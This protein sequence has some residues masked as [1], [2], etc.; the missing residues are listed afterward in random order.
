M[1]WR[2]SKQA[3]SN[4]VGVEKNRL[5]L[6]SFFVVLPKSSFSFLS[7]PE[8]AGYQGVLML[9]KKV[10]SEND[11]AIGTNLTGTRL[12]GVFLLLY[13]K[14]PA[15]SCFDSFPCDS[16]CPLLKLSTEGWGCSHFVKGQLNFSLM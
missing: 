6:F 4:V 14:I 1:H 3:G 12:S 9:F 8:W 13:F 16:E 10:Y 11:I 7:D 15:S 2:E 5:F